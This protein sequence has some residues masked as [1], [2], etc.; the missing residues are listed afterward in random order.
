QEETLVHNPRHQGEKLNAFLE[1]VIRQ[2]ETLVHNP[3]HPGRGR[4]SRDC[5]NQRTMVM[6]EGDFKTDDEEED[7]K[8]SLKKE[9]K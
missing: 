5:P 1:W 7:E 4:N 3:W 9:R 6:R 2:A 8:K